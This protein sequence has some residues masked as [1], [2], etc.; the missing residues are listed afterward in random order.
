MRKHVV[1]T[2]LAVTLLLLPLLSLTAQTT[3]F[4]R[5]QD[6][7]T[8]E[9]LP[10]V[11]VQLAGQKVLSGAEGEFEILVNL[12]PGAQAVLTI[13]NDGYQAYERDLILT[14]GRQSVGTIGLFQTGGD[15]EDLLQEFIPTIT[16]TADEFGDNGAGGSVSGLLNAN[17]DAFTSAAAF[18]FGP[19]RFR[20]R[21]YDGENTQF[22]L[23]GLP[24]NDL[25][26]GRIFWGQWGGLNRVTNYRST[27]IGL[28][29]ADYG[30]G[31]FG[32][33]SEIDLR[34]ASQR[35][36]TRV[37]YARSN[38]TYRNRVMGTY[39][40]GLNQDGWAVSVSASR[41]WAEEGYIEGTP[42]DASSYFFSV[43]KRIGR[44][45]FNGVVM[46][47]NSYRGRSTAS[48]QEMY[49]LA[50]TNFYNPNWGLQDGKKRNANIQR[51][52]QPIYQFRY[53]YDN[54]E[55]FSFT[56][57]L[58]FQT[59]RSG[60]TALDWFNAPD[61]RPIY[62]RKLPSFIQDPEQA[63]AVAERI[64]N[65]INARQIN[66]EQLYRI[67]LNSEDTVEDVDG[68]EGND[69]TGGLARYIVEERRYDNTRYAGASRFSW[70]LNEQTQLSGGLILQRQ[71]TEN[72]KLVDDLLGA[73]FY[74]DLDRFATFDFVLGSDE[75]QNDL[76]RPNR[77]LGVGDRFGYDYDLVVQ[78]G[79][80]WLQA[81]F[82]LPRIDFHVGGQLGRS[83]FWR[84]SRVI[85]GRFPDSSFR[86]SEKP[87]FTTYG[88]K[89]GATY[90]IDGRNYLQLN[91]AYVSRAPY[92]RDGFISPRTRNDIVQG[93]ENV[94]IYGVEGG[95][96]LR[97]PNFKARLIGYY[98]RFENDLRNRS[99]FLDNAI[100]DAAGNTRG[101][102]VNYIMTDIDMEHRGL[103]MAAEV[104]VTAALTAS[105]VV[106][107]G[108]YKFI[109][110]P[111][112]TTYLDNVAQ[113][114]SSRQVFIKNFFVSGT[115][116]SAY[117]FGLNYNS[118][119]YWFLNVNFN[120]FDDIYMDIFPER[121][122]YAAIS[123]VDG[124]P[125][126]R[127]E[128]VNEELLDRIVRQEKVDPAFTVDLFGG[129]SFR[130]DNTFL[131]L[132]LGVS[133]ILNKTDFITGGFEQ[134][135]FDF[136]GKDVDRF[137]NRYF[138]SF[139]RNFFASVSVRF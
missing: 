132:N 24:F 92:A 95:Y 90:K 106:A 134:S 83:Q 102:F 56:T 10:G 45:S 37:S 84:D 29:A 20:I 98:T 61:P 87:S 76:N 97:S 118:P 120:Y 19:A 12:S 23:N 77:I 54:E 7:R 65:D 5:I 3:V 52:H 57:T 74:V 85:N 25:S 31:G 96:L 51:I 38:R 13:D 62:Y 117:T 64:R 136:E 18:V 116:Q 135:R 47:S 60:N 6:E 129:K 130:F 99:F 36:Q 9:D 63:A 138:Y 44:H 126:I 68:I 35:A 32:G 114:L 113:E 122:T 110:R 109:N 93:M 70:Y 42:Y 30:F 39:S 107:L 112:V 66:W 34:A 8:G 121:R 14:G 124:Q 15:D 123:L 43:D 133:N 49:D 115:P 28:D 100:R 80:L 50:G 48:V 40:S 11:T 79:E 81:D 104:K 111:T 86:E 17:R 2:T 46:G 125:E 127:E 21:G 131:Y 82:N 108:S 72:Y 1:I 119:R 75:T 71:T 78:Q 89:A 128:A 103:E 33:I 94:N 55:N 91:G 105:A 53:D 101:G 58:A 67:N 16:I 88:G 69:R 41:R 73:E 26:S 139:G 137:P 22:N 27:V 4:G 59:G